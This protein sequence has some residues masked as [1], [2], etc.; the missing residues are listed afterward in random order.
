M[1]ASSGVVAGFADPVR[2][3]QETFRTV[4]DALAN[5]GRILPLRGIPYAPPPLLPTTAAVLLTLADFETKLW[6]DS[7]IAETTD[8]PGFLRFHMQ[9]PLVETPAEADF[10]IISDPMGMPQLAA[11][12]QGTPEYPERS[13]TLVIQVEQLANEGP[14]F[15]GP[16]IC[17]KIAFRADPL[18]ERFKEE[19]ALNRMQFPLGVDLIFVTG[20]AIAALPRS[21]RLTEGG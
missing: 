1:N 13:T 8:G 17:G 12:R 9:A 2:D 19:T 3:A 10:A 16:G 18:P 15:E 7:A 5:P 14:T 20:T 21:V 4:M 6:L 11:F